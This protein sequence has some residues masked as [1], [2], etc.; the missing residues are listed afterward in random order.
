MLR[1]LVSA[2]VQQ[3]QRVA[4]WQVIWGPANIKELG[5]VLG[6]IGSPSSFPAHLRLQIAEHLFV[7]V[8]QLSIARS[9]AM[10]LYFAPG[11]RAELL[12]QR[13]AKRLIQL[14]TDG[15]FADD[16]TTELAGV[17]AITLCLPQLAEN[18][19]AHKVGHLLQKYRQ[20]LNNRDL[21]WVR[22]HSEHL[23]DDLRAF[24]PES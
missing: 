3:W 5:C 24:L 6:R 13:L 1:R 22:E 10:M 21:E 16:E 4:N 12:C 9:L 19:L 17:L 14:V 15:H 11:E 2:L 18:N 8:N 23:P 7:K 20:Q